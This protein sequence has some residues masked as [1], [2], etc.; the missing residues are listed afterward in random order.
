[1]L[2]F[3][4]SAPVTGAVQWIVAGLGNPGTQ[5]EYT[6]H[7]AGFMALDHLIGE[8]NVRCDRLK[9]KS[10]C[11]DADIGGTR[12]L[13]MKP[14]TF[15][16]N[17]GIAIGEAARFYKIP[18]ERILVIVDDIALDVGRVRLRRNGSDGGHNGLKSIIYHLGADSFPRV[19]MGVGKKPRPD[20]DLADWVLGR[21]DK[22]DLETLKSTLDNVCQAAQMIVRGDMDK[23]MNL[24]NR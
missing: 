9:F 2:F 1:M 7:N 19:R 5:Y 17:S 21:F 3:K 13:L 11:G 14:S 24:F 15:M 4:K 10:L 6:R 20:Y 18:P 8:L 16:N 22:A 23:A 12:A